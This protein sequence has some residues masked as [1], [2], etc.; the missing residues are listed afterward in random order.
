M[1]KDFF[2]VKGSEMKIAIIGAGNVG[3]NLGRALSKVGHQISFGTNDP[4][5]PKLQGLVK[6][7]G[8]ILGLNSLVVK[9]ADIV[10]L[11]T[12]WHATKAAVESAGSLSGKIVVD[13]TNP[14]KAD[15]SDLEPGKSGAE[16]IQEWIPNSKVV[17]C[18]NQTGFENMGNPD[19]GSAQAVMFAAGDDEASCKAVANLANQIGFEGIAIGPL[20]LSRHLESLA[21]VWIHAA[22]KAKVF[23]RSAAFGVLKRKS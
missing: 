9:D 5:N 7:T 12:P 17:K 14:I 16:Q 18:F 23:D 3:G 11:A 10:I 20:K 21:W 2:R 6:D 4:N 15:F 22:L 19:Y 13:C 1:K 8:A